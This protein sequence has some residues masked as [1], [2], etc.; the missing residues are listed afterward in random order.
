[1]PMLDP[2]LTLPLTQ[3]V[4]RYE[5]GR[6]FGL[7]SHPVESALTAS[8]V[9]TVAHAPLNDAQRAMKGSRSTDTIPIYPLQTNRSELN[10]K[11]LMGKTSL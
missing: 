4:L 8:V 5:S 11:E 1:M 7:S 2:Q 10:A 9:E 6:L 3:T